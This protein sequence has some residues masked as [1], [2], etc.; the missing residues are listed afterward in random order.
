MVLAAR[1]GR[2]FF[3]RFANPGAVNNRVR[4]ANSEPASQLPQMIV[5]CILSWGWMAPRE[6]WKWVGSTAVSSGRE[7][8]LGAAEE[9]TRI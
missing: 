4:R 3:A 8:L 6:V 7:P 5:T 2:C 1:D 9:M